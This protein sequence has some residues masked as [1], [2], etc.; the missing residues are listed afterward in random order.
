ME[1]RKGRVC[2]GPWNGFM[3]WRGVFENLNFG[4]CP[5]GVMG[6]TERHT[7]VPYRAEPIPML[8]GIFQGNRVGEL[9]LVQSANNQ[10]G[11][12]VPILLVQS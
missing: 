2:G 3:F 7:T 9:H 6:E 1:G 4:K 11:T 5:S 8:C 10:A 12:M